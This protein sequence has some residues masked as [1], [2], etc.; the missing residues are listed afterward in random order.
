MLGFTE[1]VATVERRLRVSVKRVGLGLL[2]RLGCSVCDALS[3]VILLVGVAVPKSRQRVCL[4][5]NVWQRL[6]RPWR[7]DAIATA[8][9]LLRI[10]YLLARQRIEAVV[11]E[12]MFTWESIPRD[13]RYTYFCEALS[14]S[15]S[16]R[17]SATVAPVVPAIPPELLYDL[18]VLQSYR[19][20]VLRSGRIGG[21]LTE[22]LVVKR[23]LL[24]YTSDAEFHRRN[25]QRGDY[26]RQLEQAGFGIAPLK[27]ICSAYLKVGA[28]W[29]SGLAKLSA[30]EIDLFPDL[31]AELADADSLASAA[32]NDCS[33]FVT[34]DAGKGARKKGID[35]VLASRGRAVVKRISPMRV[36]SPVE[37]LT[38]LSTL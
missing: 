3:R 12:D 25:D 27:A 15:H 38:Y 18:S 10:R 37:L 36:V 8:P 11:C 19:G 33:M 24:G 22:I 1:W 23:L 9:A 6:S 13:Q 32:A 26:G 34:F 5:S 17:L 16:R 4:D 29:V 28:P 35:S 31:V 20:K 30:Q 2:V 14:A 7:S 21:P